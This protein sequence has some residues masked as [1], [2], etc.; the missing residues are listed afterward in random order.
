VFKPSRGPSPRPMTVLQEGPR[1]READHIDIMGHALL[2]AAF[3]G[4]VAPPAQLR[5]KTHTPQNGTVCHGV[6]EAKGKKAWA[7]AQR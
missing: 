1:G 3:E 5:R 7:I 2:C 4:H 6:N